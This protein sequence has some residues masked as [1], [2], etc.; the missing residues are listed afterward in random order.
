MIGGTIFLAVQ[1]IS[2]L[3]TGLALWKA[4]KNLPIYNVSL[5]IFASTY[6][7]IYY[8]EFRTMSDFEL[9]MFA[10][11]IVMVCG[12][13]SLLA[14]REEDP[15][16]KALA[17]GNVSPLPK[18]TSIAAVYPEEEARQTSPAVARG[19]L[20]VS[21]SENIGASHVSEGTMPMSP[22][23]KLPPLENTSK[24]PPL[25]RSHSAPV[26][27]QKEVTTGSVQHPNEVSEKSAPPRE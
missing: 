6:G 16:E 15:L 27:L 18:H 2:A 8:E 24:G 9:V 25:D 23:G 4:V 13:I 11:G 10:V 7:S 3:N 1:Q 19:K 20:C 26:V 21:A 5:T 12:G 14:F 17:D 22:Q